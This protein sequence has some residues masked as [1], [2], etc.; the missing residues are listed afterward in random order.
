MRSFGN[1][2]KSI[3]GILPLLVIAQRTVWLAHADH[4]LALEDGEMIDY[5]TMEDPIEQCQAYKEISCSDR[6]AVV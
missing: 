6:E 5:E 1:S 3:F 2:E 4:I